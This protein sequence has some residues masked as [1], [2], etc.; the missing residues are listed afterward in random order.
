MA[1]P[2]D[3]DPRERRRGSDT[4]R[5]HHE[6]RKSRG[7]GTT[8]TSEGSGSRS[9]QRLSMNALAQLNEMNTR[10][11]IP[12]PS[13]ARKPERKR[14]KHQPRRDEYEIVEPEYESPRRERARAHEARDADREY[15]PPR[16]TRR[17][18]NEYSESEREPESPRR[19]RR[20]RASAEPDFDDDDDEEYPNLEQE[21]RR[22]RR[23]KK[24]IVSGAIA[25]EGRST[26][27]IRGGIGSKHTS[28]NSI[29]N[30]K[31]MHYSPPKWTK[32]KKRWIAAGIGLVVLIIIIVVAVV[33][34]KKNASKS[35][36]SS[37]SSGIDEDSVPTSARGSY[38]DPFTW[39]DTTD[40][41]TTY[42]N[43]T[44]G[45][46]PVMGLFTDWDDSTQ[47][48][49]KVPALNKAW[50]DYSKTPARGVNLGGW[51]SLEPFITPS[52]FDYDSRLGII[53]EWT[54]STYLGPKTT[55]STIEKHYATFVT[56]QTFKEIQAAGL[57]H[58]RIPFS[59]WAVQTYDNDPYLF[60]ISWRYLL[61]GIEWA[62]KYG[63]RVNLDLHGLP[64][65]QNGWN[66]SGRQGPIGWLNGTNGDLNAQR[67]LDVHD[68]L[69]KFFAQ[70]RYKNIITFYG[71]ANEPQMVQLSASAVVAWTEQT[72]KMIRANG[73]TWP[74]VVFGDGFMG[75]ANWQGLLT[76]YPTLILDVHQYV[77]FNNDLIKFTHQEKIQYACSDWTEQ[78][79]Q[80]LDTSTGYGPTMFAE[81]SQADT[82]CT[83]YLTNVGWGNRW[84]GTY[85][86]GNSSTQALTPMCPTTDSS[87]TC[88]GANAGTG[89]YSDTYKQFLLMFAEAQM[90]S[91]EKGYGWWYWTWDTESAPQWSYRQGLAAGILPAKAYDRDFNCDSDV[92]NFSDSG[93]VET[94]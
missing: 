53:D 74:N 47:A 90:T 14:R 15:D 25:E 76:G 89:D 46:L 23:R 57:D 81:W 93:L 50:G 78:A 56:E 34:S 13:Q 45:D 16:R 59:Y 91:F 69:S 52:L 26:P 67:S 9:K 48:N 75:L 31:S 28:Y 94:Y 88:D 1:P 62:R 65:S 43:E 55:A 41:N 61:R 92:P 86:S 66:H 4:H 84:T 79:E 71:L 70:D 32:K 33:V 63:L 85:D 72:Y 18:Q 5:K 7:H 77:I 17:R 8:S 49:D 11:H 24:R 73:L 36:G 54:L 80:S 64:G 40:L 58:V 60:R 35:S 22:H 3:R 39:Y 44:V 51:L 6:R 68:R 27:E 12:E 19:P 30:E 83:K 2:D 21:R 42:T 29:E 10:D 20:T 38:L 87:C 82:D 37:G